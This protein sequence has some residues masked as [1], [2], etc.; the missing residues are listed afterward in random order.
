MVPIDISGINVAGKDPPE[1]FVEVVKDANSLFTGEFAEDCEHF[2][3]SKYVIAGY[4]DGAAGIGRE[5]G[6]LG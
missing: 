4:E 2:G 1:G 6:P 5:D 3:Q